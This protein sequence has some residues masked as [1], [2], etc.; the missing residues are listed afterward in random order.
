MCIFNQYRNRIICMIINF[1]KVINLVRIGHCQHVKIPIFFKKIFLPINRCSIFTYFLVSQDIALY[2]E[3]T[4]TYIKCWI[5]ELIKLRLDYLASNYKNP[6]GK[7]RVTNWV[8]WLFGFLGC[9][10]LS[11]FLLRVSW[12]YNVRWWMGLKAHVGW[13]LNEIHRSIEF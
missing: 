1:P 6:K 7:Y 11:R 5:I 12:H 2:L 10:F 4:L 8:A 9:S 3:Q 13:Y